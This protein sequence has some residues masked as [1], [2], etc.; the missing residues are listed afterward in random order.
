MSPASQ[1]QVQGKRFLVLHSF[2]SLHGNL[3][4]SASLQAASRKGYHA[5]DASSPINKTRKDKGIFPRAKVQRQSSS[6]KTYVF[7]SVG[8]QT[9]LTFLIVSLQDIDAMMKQLSSKSCYPL[10]FL[11]LSVSV[12][13]ESICSSVIH[14]IR[15]LT[16]QLMKSKKQ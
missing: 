9:W 2:L 1:Q 14:K 15:F 7:C 6:G 10:P 16:D 4:Q 13:G 5:N 12:N 3:N 11:S 8:E